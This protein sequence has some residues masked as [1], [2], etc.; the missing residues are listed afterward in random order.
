[1][2]TE[3]EPETPIGNL[4]PSEHLVMW[5][6]N[7]GFATGHADTEQDML[8]EVSTQIKELQLDAVRYRWLR[9]QHAT[10]MGTYLTKEV[11]IEVN[12]DA[13]IDR[14]LDT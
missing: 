1:M 5:V 6:L 14:N 13:Y 9:Q 11:S 10:G 8:D 7:L 4:G 3:S 2:T 12:L